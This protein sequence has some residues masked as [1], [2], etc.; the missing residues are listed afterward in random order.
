M[1]ATANF[2]G[3]NY[4]LTEAPM[5]AVHQAAP[6]A[7]MDNVVGVAQVFTDAVM[8][9]IMHQ[10]AETGVLQERIATQKIEMA[11]QTDK[12]QYLNMM[13]EKITKRV[14]I[15][16]RQFD[17]AQEALAVAPQ[18]VAPAPSG[19][20]SVARAPATTDPLIQLLDQWQC[21]DHLR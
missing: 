19:T 2:D 1:D 11:I 4:G 16:E 10:A 14:D 18:S 7:V 12:L 9:G 5:P 21:S 3:W 15:L 8:P 20:E 6:L 17:T 13:L